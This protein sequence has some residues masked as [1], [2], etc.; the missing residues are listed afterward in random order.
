M[1]S[2]ATRYREAEG[3]PVERRRA[4]RLPVAIACASAHRAGDAPHD[5]ILR[6]LSIYG[7]RIESGR[8]H[9]P[10][11][12]VSLRLDGSAPVVATVVWSEAG[13]AGCRFVEPI[14]RGLL[15]AFVLALI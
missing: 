11:A 10:G 8:S 9:I 1:A 2:R 3:A 7:C 15:R 12:S 14:E 6:D 4:R 13:M 5:A